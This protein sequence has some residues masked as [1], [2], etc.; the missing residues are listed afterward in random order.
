[1]IDDHERWL[2]DTIRQIQER[3][4]IAEPYVQA[5]A[6]LR[7]QRVPPVLVPV[8]ALRGCRNRHCECSAGCCTVPGYYDG[9]H[10]PETCATCVHSTSP[11]PKC[12]LCA[13]P[14]EKTSRYQPI[15]V[16]KD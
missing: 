14:T 2:G 8:D 5:L 12:G 15:P 6:K 9:R 4:A 1:M 13:G 16:K 7:A 11:D 3:A 10:A